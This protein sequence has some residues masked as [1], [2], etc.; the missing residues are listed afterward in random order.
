[1][2]ILFVFPRLLLENPK[3]KEEVLS[4]IDAGNQV[5]F[6]NWDKKNKDEEND[7]ENINISSIKNFT[8]FD[9]IPYPFFWLPVWRK[10]GFKKALQ[11]NKKDK[12]DAIQAVDIGALP[13]GVKL[14]R[15]LNV[16]LIYEAREIF[17]NMTTAKLAQ[18][19]HR[20]IERI[21]IHNTSEI[22][23]TSK[24]R[25]I[26]YKNEYNLNK[27]PKG[28]RNI[29]YSKEI[30]PDRELF[31]SFLKKRFENVRN[32]KILLYAG[33]IKP[34]RGLKEAIKESKHFDENILFVIMGPT[35]YESYK[36]E[37]KEIINNLNLNERVAFFPPVSWKKALKFMSSADAGLV[38]YK[39]TSLN[40][41]LCT[42]RKLWELIQVG[43][44]V[45]GCNLPQIKRIVKDNNFGSIFNLQKEGNLAKKVNELLVNDEKLNM[46]KERIKKQSD[47]YCWE[48]ESQKLIHVYKNLDGDF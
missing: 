36:K 3:I 15:K 7:H 42:P 34:D 32:K 40:N 31:L 37:L 27:T 46:V 18:L 10:K 26:A 28:I 38:T 8:K 44:P 35:N 47:K 6:I 16:P 39:P 43:T 11:I 14:K 45:I 30:E 20:L 12:I 33:G 9:S 13:L 21:F 48:K 22:I 25:A 5:F 19:H 23:C 4:L 24:E 1:M 17:F 2:N 29:P 41:Y